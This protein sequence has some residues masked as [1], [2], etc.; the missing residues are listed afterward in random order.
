M[1]TLSRVVMMESHELNDEISYLQGSK[2][3]RAN[4]RNG[5]SGMRNAHAPE[6]IK[7]HDFTSFGNDEY[8]LPPVSDWIDNRV[9]N[10]FTIEDA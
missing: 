10:H 2:G 3:T 5:W 9:R 4:H 7:V 8:C 6:Y 1:R